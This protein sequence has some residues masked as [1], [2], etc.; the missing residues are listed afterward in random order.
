MIHICFS[1]Y[2]KSGSYSKFIGTT[3]LSIFENIA[4]PPISISKYSYSARQ[5]FDGR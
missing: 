1:L 5:L 3:M 4:P 2:D